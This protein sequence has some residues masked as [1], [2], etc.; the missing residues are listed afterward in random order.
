M[1]VGQLNT[2]SAYDFKG[3]I[4]NIDKYVSLAKAKGYTH[5]GIKGSDTFFFPKLASKCL[6]ENVTPVFLTSIKI[7]SEEGELNAALVILD[8]TGYK[9][10]CYLKN[11]LN[12]ESI[13]INEL[14]KISEGLAIIIE[15]DLK[16]E[17]RLFQDKM[18]RE[19]AKIKK[20]FG[21]DFY[22]GIGLY[23]KEDYE[24]VNQ[25]IEFASTCSYDVIPFHEV[26]YLE[27]K[28][29]YYYD[30]FLSALEKKERQNNSEGP[31]FLL[32]IQSLEKIYNKNLLI[33]Q[34]KLLNKIK[35]DFYR[36]IGSIISFSDDDKKLKDKAYEGMRRLKKDTKQYQERLDYELRIISDMKFSSYFLL[37]EDYV[38]FAK[39]NNIKIGPSRGSAGGSLTCYFLGITSL[40]PIKFNLSFERF[41]NPMRVTMPDIDIDFDSERRDEVISYLYNKYNSNPNQVCNIIVFSTLKPRSAI[42]L[43]APVLGYPDNTLSPLLSSISSTASSFEK[44]EKDPYLGE[45]FKENLKK[46]SY[47]ELI[48]VAKKIIDLPVNISI[49]AS[50]VIVSEK[51]ISECCQIVKKDNGMILCGY[52]FGAMEKLGFL[53]LDILALSNLTFIKHVEE[54]IVNNKKKLPDIYSDL[55][56]KDV[57]KV[58]C[59]KH[60]NNIFQL[61]NSLITLKDIDL[62]QPDSFKDLCELIDLIRP[63]AKDYVYTFAQ[64]KHNKEKTTYLDK[65]LEEVL[66]DT[67]G[68]MLY[69]E[70]IMETVK[71]IAG[72]SLSE[73]DLLRRAIS[74]KNEEE[75]KK[76]YSKFISGAK[77][78]NISIDI[79]NKIYKDIEKFSNYGF[80]KAHSYGYGLI[81]YTLLY[82][83][84]FF[85]EEFYSVSIEESR[86]G[87]KEFVQIYKELSE[88][89]FIFTNPDINQS[90]DTV[91]FVDK[92]IYLSLKIKNINSIFIESILKERDKGKYNSYLNFLIRN[93]ELFNSEENRKALNSLLDAGAF[94]SLNEYRMLLKENTKLYLDA[95]KFYSDEQE[96]EDFIIN[97]DK[98]NRNINIFE[99]LIQEKG[100]VGI[101]ASTN[102]DNLVEEK[103]GYKPY[104]VSD[105]TNLEKYG[106]IDIISNLEEYTIKLDKNTKINKGSCVMI[107]GN[108]NNTYKTKLIDDIK[109]AKMKGESK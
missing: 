20:I 103:K 62:I 97:V 7:E 109:E 49:H 76:Y 25:I 58:L 8:E 83:K 92:K 16:F 50:G 63:G 30:I 9:N 36:K 15:T 85:P 43:V 51:P 53:K 28:D 54:E 37:V 38:S 102:L 40:D 88:R 4:I 14:K 95:I 108:F 70:Q 10:I 13:S 6:E 1:K 56:N 78:K 65:S 80:N 21:D 106:T 73:A 42:K 17:F 33:N 101:I 96:I 94:D 60:I 99:Q 93:K 84:T 52:E 104:I 27:K 68:I 3:S 12:S 75:I 72:F 59:K 100:A 29:A 44:A 31:N 26:K 46:K 74:K 61:D 64:R 71:I 79:A 45:A 47:A 81:T 91:K 19:L 69:Q 57:Y 35:F 89:G 5:I 23:T 34:E 22:L 41:L 77:N 67:Y 82:Y 39:N 105:N 2:L 24:N 90:S 32:S 66:K 87:S 98:G 55:E 86:I 18:A 107:K 48:D 11:N